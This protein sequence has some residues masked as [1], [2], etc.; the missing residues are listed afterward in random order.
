MG[1]G[2]TDEVGDF[3]VSDVSSNAGSKI[4][5]D[6]KHAGK[7]VLSCTKS[8]IETVFSKT[9]DVGAVPDTIEI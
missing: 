6:I 5:T 1:Y 4:V 9:V 2:L 3:D 8:S 7:F